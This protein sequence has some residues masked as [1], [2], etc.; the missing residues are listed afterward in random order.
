MADY[1][2]WMLAG[3]I[4]LLQT[5]DTLRRY[6]TAKRRWPLST[7]LLQL[8]LLPAITVGGLIFVIKVV[9]PLLVRP[10]TG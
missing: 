8:A 2:L 6:F 10:I 5:L 1:T 9:L 7:L 3:V 4:V